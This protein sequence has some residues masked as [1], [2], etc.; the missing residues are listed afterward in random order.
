MIDSPAPLSAEDAPARNGARPYH[1][2][3]LRAAMVASALSLIESGGPGELSLR[4]AA[5]DIGVSQTA[6]LYHF[7]NKFGLLVAVATEG[8]RML[9]AHRRAR[10]EG[11]VGARNRL[12]AAMLAYVEFGVGHPALFRLMTGPDIRNHSNDAELEKAASDTYASLRACMIDYLVEIGQSAEPAHRAS[13]AAWATSHGIV[14]ILLDREN[15][16]LLQPR[17]DPTVIADEIID[18]LIAGLGHI[19][20][21][22]R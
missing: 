6:P 22:P 3:N 10:M 20:E 12:R 18:I 15:S 4:R 19:G 17:R 7:G 9:L 5:R 21:G 1:H 8:F 13:L 14:T 16:P 11:Q 2:G